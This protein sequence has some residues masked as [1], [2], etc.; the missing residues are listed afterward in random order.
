MFSYYLFAYNN[1]DLKNVLI[2]LRPFA[3]ELHKNL[4]VCF[5][6][7]QEKQKK[8]RDVFYIKRLVDNRLTALLALTCQF[9]MHF[10]SH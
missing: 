4:D 6:A 8:T 9:K 7:S 10:F 3:K 5:M 2:Y 1:F